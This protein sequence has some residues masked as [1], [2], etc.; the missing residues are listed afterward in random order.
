VVKIRIFFFIAYF[1]G[2]WLIFF[3]QETKVV[4]QVRGILKMRRTLE[5][6]RPIGEIT[7]KDH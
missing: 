5:K 2:E 4:R 3:N 6:L 1:F 7:D